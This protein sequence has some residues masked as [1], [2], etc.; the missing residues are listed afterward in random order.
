[1]SIK[2]PLFKIYWD[3]DDVKAVKK[4]IERGTYWATGPEITEFETKLAQYVG[5]K[6]AV[7]FNSGTSALHSV[8]L[9]F[10]IQKGDEIIMPS[11]SF[12]AT[13]NATLYVNA[14]PVFAEIEDETYGLEPKDVR[15]KITAR[16]K[17]IMPVHYGG[18]P[19]LYI[20]ELKE[21]AEEHGLLLIEDAAESLGA[22]IRDRMVGTFG[23]AAMFSFCQNKVITT[24]EGGVVTTNSQE[25]YRK[26]KLLVSHG[27]LEDSKYF[28]SGEVQDYISLGYNFRMPSMTAALGLS[29]LKKIEKTTKR[30]RENAKYYTTSLNKI[31]N[32]TPPSPPKNYFHRYQMYTIQVNANGRDKLQDHLNNKGIS[33]KVYFEPIHLTKFYREKFGFKE[34]YLPLTEKI[35]KKV[36]TLPMFVEFT[37]EELNYVVN[38][39]GEFYGR[40]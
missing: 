40:K 3:E 15:K 20:N 10:N 19:C 26:L 27:R 5:T 29:Q 7:V 34:G 4:V 35:S 30:R 21:I 13:A 37:N 11:F 16:T 39:I 38:S 1:M 36:L 22:K 18:C 31:T 32:I 9:A 24:G 12:I 23:D 6:Y 33:T 14:K 8:L 17:A 25:I 2:I 28:E